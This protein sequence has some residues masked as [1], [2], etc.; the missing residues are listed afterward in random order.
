[1]HYGFRIIEDLCDG[2][3]N[4]MDAK[5]FKTIADFRGKSLPSHLGFQGLRSFFPRRGPHRRGEMHQVQLVLHRL[6]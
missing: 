5:G 6:Q 1:M 4:W 2:L 3:S